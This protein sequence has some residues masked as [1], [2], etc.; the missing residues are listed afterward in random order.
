[1]TWWGTY[2]QIF[3]GV[4]F[5]YKKK[6]KKKKIKGPGRGINV[7]QVVSGVRGVMPCIFVCLIHFMSGKVF[8]KYVL[9]HYF[10]LMNKSTTAPLFMTQFFRFFQKNE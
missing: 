8:F 1:M 5:R 2:A 3:R 6:K 10:F 9:I 4:S 7:F